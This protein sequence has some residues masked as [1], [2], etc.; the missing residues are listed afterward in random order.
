MDLYVDATR[1]LPQTD[2]QYRQTH[3]SQG[4]FLELLVLALSKLG[5]GAGIEYF[6][7]GEYANDTLESRPVARV[8]LQAS[9]ATLDPLFAHIVNRSSN[10]RPYRLDRPVPEDAVRKLLECAV[11]QSEVAFETS[12]RFEVAPPIRKTLSYLATAAMAIEVADR[13]RNIETAKWFRFSDAEIERKRDG[14][15]LIHNGTTGMR[16]WVAETFLLDREGAADPR[17]MFATGAIDIA[18]AQAESTPA[19]GVITTSSNSRRAQ[20]L[21]GRCYARVALAAESQGLAMHPMSQVLEEYPAMQAIKGQF[22]QAIGLAPGGT[23][24]MFFRLGYAERA[25]HTPRRDAN[26]MLR[27]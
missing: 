9:T 6:P 24:Q 26:E 15:G 14:F 10:K 8:R 17:G 18:R 19:F 3:V 23:A 7:D 27:T 21:A 11:E 1:L 4:T 16:R 5:Y 25:P 12:L 22:E 20:L 13:Q 2:P